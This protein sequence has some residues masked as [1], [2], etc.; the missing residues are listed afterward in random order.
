MPVSG[1]PPAGATLAIGIAS[2]IECRSASIPAMN[3]VLLARLQDWSWPMARLAEGVE[4]LARA[5]AMPMRED[6]GAL[7]AAALAHCAAHERTACLHWAVGQWGLEI[8][9]VDATIPEVAKTLQQIGPAIVPLAGEIA[10]CFLLLVGLRG[11]KLALLNPSGR[12][13]KVPLEEI[14]DALCWEQ[15]APALPDIDALL[16]ATQM[17]TSRRQQARKSLLEERLSTRSAGPFW[18]LRMAPGAP[19]KRQL[20]LAGVWQRAFALAALLIAA[21]GFETATWAVLGSSVLA[22]RND[23]GWLGV[24][25]WLVLAIVPLRFAANGVSADLSLKVGVLIKKRLM[26]GAARID[27]DQIRQQGLGHVMGRVMEAA[28]LES[29]ALS[30]GLSLASATVELALAA[31]VLSMG[32]GGGWHVLLLGVWM[33]V[34]LTVTWRFGGRTWRWTSV[35]L[36][37]THELLERMIGHRTRL[38]QERSARRDSE[39][40]ASLSRYADS[41]RAMDRSTTPLTALM[42]GAWVWVAIAVLTPAFVNAPAGNT[43]TWLMSLG[44]IWLAQRALG[45]LTAGTGAWLRAAYAWREVSGLFHAGAARPSGKRFVPLPDSNL[46][47]THSSPLLQADKLSFQYTQGGTVFQGLDLSIAPRDKLLIQGPSGG[48][49]STLAALITGARSPDAGLLLMQG[50]DLPTLGESW[51]RWA[52]QA[53]QFHD[54]HVLTGTFAYN[55]LL[56]RDWP[57]SQASLAE[58]EQLCR[59]LGLGSLLDRM[60]GGLM[61]RV[62]ETGWQ[63]SHGERSR[64]FLARALLQKAPL[65]VLDETFAALDPETL[66]QCL[67]VARTRSQA[68]VVIAHP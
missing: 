30:G 65:T 37:L 14:R 38:A 28:S 12:V 58:A 42:P 18:M 1:N 8:E 67:G 22:G 60:P 59:E 31:W 5:V 13:I 68:L 41:S 39:E 2:N 43:G 62:G 15:E 63:L 50:L 27:K 32:A 54:N 20:M 29:L 3:A 61:Q 66:R 21:Y 17:P 9:E 45:G 10:N 51:R 7:V 16:N 46:Q 34:T 53:P 4:A 35:R 36:G 11:R 6:A 56:G 24:W 23:V 64:L 49:K 47:R 55:L 40:D 48:G 44:G 52:T 33:V 25:A 19:F 57:A 26:A